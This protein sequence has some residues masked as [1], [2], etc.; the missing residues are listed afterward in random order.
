MKIEVI[1]LKEIKNSKG[2]ILKILQKKEKFFNKFGEAYFSK[3]N[4][5][6]IKAWKKHKKIN[7]N[8]TVISGAVKFAFYNDLNK[9]FSYI[10]LKEEDKK[11]IYIPAGIWFGFKGLD[12][13]NIILSIASGIT[14]KKEILRKTLKEIRFN[15]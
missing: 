11:K 14:T 13:K 8:L 3:V 10:I 5:K 15:W 1:N 2:N 6:S 7:L 12:T 4:K 9:K